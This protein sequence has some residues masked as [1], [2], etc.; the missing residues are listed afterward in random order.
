MGTPPGAREEVETF[1]NYHDPS[2]YKPK[3]T[4]PK[5][6]R[7]STP[8]SGSLSANRLA[9]SAKKNSAKKRTS[10]A[11]PVKAAKPAIFVIGIDFGTTFT[12]FTYAY[13]EE[14]DKLQTITDWVDGNADDP[15]TPSA[16]KFK[17]NG[18]DWGIKANNIPTALRWFKLLLVNEEDLPADVRASAQLKE[19]RQQV[20]SIRKS[21][22]DVASEYLDCVWTHCLERM[23]TAEGEETVDTSR[24]HVVIT[25]PAI[26]PNYA[27]ERMRQ[28]V[29]KAGILKQRR[30]VGKTTLDF[31]FEPE[32]AALAALS[33]V[34]GRHNI[35]I[36]DCFVIVDCGGGTVDLISYKVTKTQPMEVEEVVK[37]EGALCGAIFV[38]ERFEDLLELKLKLISEE[39]LDLIDDDDIPEMMDRHWENGIRKLFTGTA[40]EWTIRY[41]FN[42]VDRHLMAGSR[43][44]PTF[45]ITS[46]EVEE[47]FRPI[48]E[49]I[50]ELVV[51]QINAVSQKED[52]LPKYV[53]L[54]GGFG[55]S[56]YLHTYLKQNCMDVEV[57]QRQ[58]FE[59]WSAISRGAV[60]HGLAKLK[61]DTP[62]VAPIRARIAR[63][64]YG[65]VCQE[66]WNDEKH[67][68]DDHILDDDTG[69]Y[70]AVRQMKWVVRLGDS[71]EDGHLARYEFFK[72][73]EEEP[74]TL[75]T[76][77]YVSKA[78]NPPTRRDESVKVYCKVTWDINIDWDSL[79]IYQN[80]H[81]KK[82][83][84][85]DYTVSMKCDGGSSVFSILHNGRRQAAKNV[86]VEVYENSDI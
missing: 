74:K 4:T 25:L 17:R 21:A 57:L 58:G 46:G 23:K 13:S 55:R 60:L 28:A 73:L 2:E 84:R 45:T 68:Q 70:K 31:I 14:A 26:W 64:S 50:Q 52:K 71:I 63:A 75:E 67:D 54:V 9:A 81:G 77:I 66:K 5:R 61:I 86:S 16:I 80:T 65:V 41:P 38:D 32:A 51:C 36:G 82:Y 24:F 49:K 30:G 11:K 3:L 76:I 37:G 62:L 83:R 48:V 12:G 7:P 53:I 35:K 56:K 22:V 34:D 18:V 79:A 43:G 20:K 29:D 39:A 42:L 8:D 44:F 6:K 10:K 27:R 72:H 78:E 85:L 47:V 69:E 1:D 19:L 15:K 33:G 59:P 40:Q